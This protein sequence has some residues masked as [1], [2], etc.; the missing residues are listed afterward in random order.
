MESSLFYPSKMEY[1]LRI[2]MKGFL[3]VFH[4]LLSYYYNNNW[5]IMCGAI[6]KK[7]DN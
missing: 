5:I 3:R 4:F 7:E 2:K 1:Y 6:I